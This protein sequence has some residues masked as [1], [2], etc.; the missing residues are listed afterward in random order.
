MSSIQDSTNSSPQTSTMT[1]CNNSM[2]FNM[3]MIKIH[4]NKS[5]KIQQSTSSRLFASLKTKIKIT[6]RVHKF[7]VYQSRD[8]VRSRIISE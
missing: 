8:F 1:N 3:H 4:Y 5:I 2:V 7:K 6:T